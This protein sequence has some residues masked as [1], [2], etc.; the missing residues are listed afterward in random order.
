MKDPN[1]QFNVRLSEELRALIKEAAEKNNRSQTAEVSARLRESFMR[2]GA[3]KDGG[4]VQ[5]RHDQE[6]R[7]LVAVM[8]LMTNQLDLMRKELDA[9]LRGLKGDEV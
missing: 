3:I 6:A 5:P 8:E 9:R 1:P 7:E 2:E 4:T